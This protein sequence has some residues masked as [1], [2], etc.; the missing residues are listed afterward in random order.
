VFIAFGYTLPGKEINKIRSMK[1]GIV[2]RFI[3]VLSLLAFQLYVSAQDSVQVRKNQSND[4]TAAHVGFNKRPAVDS[5]RVGNDSLRNDLKKLN[6]TFLANIRTGSMADFV[7]Q[8]NEKSNTYTATNTGSAKDS[9]AAIKNSI[10]EEI[11]QLKSIKGSISNYSNSLTITQDQIRNLVNRYDIS[12]SNHSRAYQYLDNAQLKLSAKMDSLEVINRTI[13]ELITKNQRRLLRLDAM[14]EVK[15][16]SK[17]VDSTSSKSSIW[18]ANTAAISK[19]VL[20]NNIRTNYS[21]NKSIDKYVNR[22]DWASRILLIVLGLGYCYWIVRVS[23]ILRQNDSEHKL[24][25]DAI[26][27]KTIIFLLTLLPFVNFFTPSFILQ[28]SQLVI[29]LIF[30][31]L[32][33]HRMSGLQRKIAIILIVFYLLDVFV[34]MIV[35][36]DLFLRIVCIAF[37]LIALGLVSYT[38]RRIKNADSPGYISNFIYVVFAILNITAI[39]LNVIGHVEHSRSFSIACA[40][41]LVQSFTLQYFADMIKADVRNQFKKDRLT[42]GFWMRFNEQRTLAII[43]EILRIV[44]VLLAIIVLANNLQFI[45]TLLAASEVFFG[46]VRSI[47]SISF[48][49]GNLVVAVLLLLVANWFQK[50]ISLIVLGGEDGQL[51][52]VYN[53][54][55]TLFPLFRLAII[56][57]GFFMAISA[58]GMSLDKLTVVIGA[59]S[60]GIG[61]GMQNIINNFVSGIILVFD[62]PFRV[63][64]QIELADK[65]GRVK[66]IGI[67]ASVLKTADGA[68]VIIPNGDLL[69]GRVVN[70]TLSQEYSKTSFV[71]HIDRQADLDK[72]KEWIKDAMMASPYYIQE[73][74]SGISIQDIS[75]EMIYLSVYC[76]VNA[77][78]NASSLKNDV[79]LVLYK[80][81]EAEG[82]KFYS[83]IPPKN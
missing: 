41:G 39:T 61:L 40:V 21:N 49:L 73:R 32:L 42:A 44:C 76:W 14:H 63:G 54:K 15:N 64:D 1:L 29:M 22:T 59:L 66:E 27:G 69:S 17:K 20:L 38:K 77:A 57:I 30:M 18:K 2:K 23:Y 53:Q 9:I 26:V 10:H 19:D 33:R 79:L 83:V 24:A 55:M 13:D 78:G 74:D 34:N 75:A 43:T 62:K 45:E 81:F 68:D 46:K 50:N 11:R 65:K 7:A 8:L 5:T 82:L 25:I 4:R 12:T 56:L 71:L 48:T 51:S 60:V 35:S 28:A 47:G 36:D 3:F 6:L 58:L 67:R 37:N 80:K 72:A 70:W 52:Q 31:F 16:V